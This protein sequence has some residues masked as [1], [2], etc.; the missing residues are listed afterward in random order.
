[1]VS[2]CPR[3]STVWGGHRGGGRGPAGLLPL[4]WLWLWSQDREV[5]ELFA[6]WWQNME[7]QWL[8]HQSTCVKCASIKNQH[9][10]TNV[11]SKKTLNMTAGAPLGCLHLEADMM[12][13]NVVTI[14]S[15]KTKLI[16][17][18][19]CSA[20]VWLNTFCPK[21]YVW[22]YGSLKSANKKFP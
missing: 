13:C 12:W 15:E 10:S 8:H 14:L 18:W 11:P 17:R 2:C 16:A 20:F 5:R 6:G 22:V 21:F 1:M 9:Q 4:A 3:W 7:Q 19:W